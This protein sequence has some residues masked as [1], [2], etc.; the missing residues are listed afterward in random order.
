MS[1]CGEEC[2]AGAL[3]PKTPLERLTNSTRLRQ[4]LVHVQ[5]VAM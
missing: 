1:R 3:L 5:G 4:S 2:L